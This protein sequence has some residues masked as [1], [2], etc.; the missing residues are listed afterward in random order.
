[1]KSSF[2][3]SENVSAVALE[4]GFL[5]LITTLRVDSILIGILFYLVNLEGF[6]SPQVLIYY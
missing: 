1:M 4:Q 6:N 5:S 3:V 2:P